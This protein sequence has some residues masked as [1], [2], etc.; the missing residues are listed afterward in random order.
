MSSPSLTPPALAAAVPIVPELLEAHLC[1][2]Q[3]VIARE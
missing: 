2:A 3:A 1:T